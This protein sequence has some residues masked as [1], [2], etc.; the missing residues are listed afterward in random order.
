MAMTNEQSAISKSI[1]D[2]KKM[3]EIWTSAGDIERLRIDSLQKKIRC[4]IDSLR[5]AHVKLRDSFEGKTGDKTPSSAEI[6]PML[7][8]RNGGN[9][10]Y[11]IK[12]DST[13]Y[14][15]NIPNN[16]YVYSYDDYGNCIQ[17]IYYGNENGTW[18][19]NFRYNIIYND[20][21]ENIGEES[22]MWTGSSWTPESRNIRVNSSYR[23]ED[24]EGYGFY[25]PLYDE[26]C[27]GW[28]DGTWTYANRYEYS[29]D[30]YGQDTG[31][32]S[33]VFQDGEW[34]KDTK[35]EYVNTDTLITNLYYI[36]NGVE[37]APNG[38][39]EYY[40]TDGEYT[41]IYSYEWKNNAWS[42]TSKT[43]Y[44][45]DTNGYSS[46]NI[47]Y[48]YKNGQWINA[49]KT[50]LVYDN[51]GNNISTEYY[52][53]SNNYWKGSTKS[54][55]EYNDKGLQV[56]YIYYEWYDYY[57]RWDPERKREYDYDE[58]GNKILEIYYDYYST[59]YNRW[60][61][62]YKY[63]YRYDERGNRLMYAYYKWSSNMWKGSSKTESVYNEQNRESMLIYY[64]WSNNAWIYDTK[65][66]YHYE[67]CGDLQNYVY[68]KYISGN[69]TVSAYSENEYD[70]SVPYTMIAMRNYASF[71]MPG[72]YEPEFYC[73]KLRNKYYTVNSGIQSLSSETIYYY[74][75]IEVRKEQVFA[76]VDDINYTI[77]ENVYY[78]AKPHGVTLGDSGHIDNVSVYYTS[79]DGSR[80]YEM[81]T[82]P[83]VYFCSF[84]VPENKYFYATT[85]ENVDS[86]VIYNFYESE[87]KVLNDYYN[88]YENAGNRWN[89]KWDLE[90]GK[91][92]LS[93]LPGITMSENHIIG[94]DLQGNGISSFP[95]HLLSLPNLMSLNIASNKLE[96]NL[97]DSIAKEKK[98][99]NEY[100]CILKSLNVSNNKYSGNVTSLV[101]QFPKL[102]RLDVSGCCFSSVMPMIPSSVKDL[103]IQGQTIDLQIKLNMSDLNTEEITRTLPT[104][105]LYDHANQ[106]YSTDIALRLTTSEKDWAMTLACKNGQ[107]TIPYVS[108]Q[109][110]FYGENGETLDVSVLHSN[111]SLE[112]ST[113]RISLH[114]DEGDSNFDGKVNILDLQ[115]M[116]NYMFDEYNNKPYNFTASN[117]W[118]DDVIN[119][120][121]A[122]VMV[123]LLLDEKIETTSAKV[124]NYARPM[125]V[126]SDLVYISDGK[127]IMNAAEPVS[128]FDIIVA[129]DSECNLNEALASVGFTC[130][131]KRYGDQVHIIGY[132]LS[133]ATL[134]EGLN[135]LGRTNA[136]VVTYSMLADPE[137]NEIKTANGG[138]PTFIDN[139]VSDNR[140]TNE[141]YRITLGSRN[142]V[143]IDANGKKY[144]ITEK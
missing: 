100:I 91:E 95:Y 31:H 35:A 126:S 94:I 109:N 56:S 10:N 79:K 92:N 42:Y 103:N 139:N 82:E 133:G 60:D 88:D 67:D 37:W 6:R 143:V 107:V 110:A 47:R 51:V 39:T 78:D 124:V 13:V 75:D 46:G 55:Y 53:W 24:E 93:K 116:L 74:S 81:P 113:F 20:K 130:S 142:S 73:K 4:D 27:N 104:I 23:F 40:L 96:G 14:Y 132:S 48:E 131:V 41:I 98:L 83:G 99:H 84:V 125:D 114:F 57:K 119:V 12:L 30:D 44:S 49:S 117:L 50:I 16:K 101:A 144:M 54:V 118:K 11:T 106:T 1:H 105:V 90:L 2:K 66:E 19:P 38:K 70:N 128:A 76:K 120:Q 62:Y 63:E 65:T 115:T 7:P 36:W 129:N 26:Y 136:G 140:T 43:E 15:N 77:T 29:Y 69:W 122:V 80:F 21:N 141:V 71:Y 52:T 138:T 58:Y 111:G 59:S 17:E 33:Y 135:I 45:Y 112:G 87:W 9:P 25:K 34:I 86:F 3:Y 134:P 102:E 8:K 97:A 127:L 32:V 28:S 18:Y 68:Y 22:Y 137:A 89:R 108:E 121:D 5:L 85:L 61:P 72:M 123:N 64:G